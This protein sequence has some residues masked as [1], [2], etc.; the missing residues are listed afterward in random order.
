[1]APTIPVPFP[2]Q[3]KSYHH[4]DHSSDEASAEVLR[5]RNDELE[6]ELKK[7]VEREEKMKGE[8][9]KAWRRLKVAEEAEE[10]LCF[11]LG[12]FEAEAVDQ[13]RAYRARLSNLMEQ[14]SAAQKLLQSNASQ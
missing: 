4:H 1:M 13:A 2:A 8:L 6:K 12:E 7:S 14:L 3:S 5:K 10:R 11:Q 9:Q